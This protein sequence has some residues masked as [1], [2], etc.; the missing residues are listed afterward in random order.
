MPSSVAMFEA[1]GTRAF[2]SHVILV[3]KLTASLKYLCWVIYRA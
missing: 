3:Y 2:A 1:K